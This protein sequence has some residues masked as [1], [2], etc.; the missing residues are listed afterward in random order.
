MH[1]LPKL[2]HLFDKL[3]DTDFKDLQLYMDCEAEL[4]QYHSTITA[5]TVD[6]KIQLC[7][8]IYT[9]LDEYKL[10]SQ[11]YIVSFLAHIAPNIKYTRELLR[12]C[13]NDEVF[14][15]ETQFYFYY[16]ITHKRFIQAYC[17]D[18]GASLLLNRFYKHI[19]LRYKSS[20]TD[21]MCWIP[22]EE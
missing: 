9:H 5:F 7:D 19:Y 14:T 4:R 22:P 6:E 20:I 18:S 11:I 1:L 2:T 3:N 8:S 12:L 17:F 15:P 13:Q 10:E 21:E 16:Q